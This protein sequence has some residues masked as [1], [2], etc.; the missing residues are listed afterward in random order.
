MCIFFINVVWI[1]GVFSFTDFLEKRIE[2][3][4]FL[5]GPDNPCCRF[6][7]RIQQDS[8]YINSSYK[9]KVIYETANFIINDFIIRFEGSFVT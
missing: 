6:I 3:P 7:L 2:F 9:N 1:K 8:I 4:L 5:G